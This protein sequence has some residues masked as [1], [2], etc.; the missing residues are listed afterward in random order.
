M[1]WK[2]AHGLVLLIAPIEF[3]IPG[4]MIGVYI[5][6]IVI[7]VVSMA[8]MYW[9]LRKI[10]PQISSVLATFG[11]LVLIL[12]P[13]QLG[14]FTYLCMDGHTAYFLVWLLCSYKLKNPILVA[15]CGYLLAFNKI[16]GLV[17]YV[18]FLLTM[19]LF[20]MANTAG[21]NSVQRILNWW[22]WKKVLLWTAPAVIYFFSSVL[23]D[24]LT[25][26]NFY[27]SYVA[28]T[29]GLK[30]IRGLGNTF[31]QSFVYG[32]RWGFV[33]LLVICCVLLLLRRR[34]L[35]Q[36]LTT[37]GMKML[38]AVMIGCF[39]VFAVLCLYR[40][41]AECPRYTALFNIFYALSFPVMIRLLTRKNWMQVVLGGL[42]VLLLLI[43]TYWTIDPVLIFT[44]ESAYSGKKPIY[45]LALPGDTRVA[46]KLGSDFGKGYM[47]YGDLFTYNYEHVFYDDL[48]DQALAEIA[49]EPDT[50]LVLLD[51]IYYEMHLNGNRYPIY[52]NTRTKHRT[53]DGSDPDSIFLGNNPY[54][55]TDWICE[56]IVKFDDEF[57]LMVPARVDPSTAIESIEG[58]GYRL[59]NEI[60]PENFYGKMS[61]YS[62]AHEAQ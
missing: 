11:S 32:L 21:R 14:M 36:V 56:K 20:E 53:Y 59:V 38:L 42:M 45:M 43:Q 26:Q 6:N 7:T 3:L 23:A 13:Y 4:E 34:K 57:H 49:P 30:D 52:W 10:C 35:S 50:Q 18:F 8:C 9:L 29:I 55:T 2:W 48:L 1:C 39:A 54:V 17:F 51:V 58:Q 62:F 47:V 61:V 33:I 16:T 24:D 25:V 19:G 46:M 5:A 40:G 27:G 44:S 37:G 15:F 22:S 12:S 28:A 41:D 31:M 60:H